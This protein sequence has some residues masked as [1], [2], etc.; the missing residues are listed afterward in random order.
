LARQLPSI[1]FGCSPGETFIR[2]RHIGLAVNIIVAAHQHSDTMA[3]L[4]A[5]SADLK[6]AQ[7]ET[8]L[9]SLR[10]QKGGDSQRVPDSTIASKLQGLRWVTWV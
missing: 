1:G 9:G 4:Q 8:S 10:S 2:G 5:S 6:H 3:L 7:G